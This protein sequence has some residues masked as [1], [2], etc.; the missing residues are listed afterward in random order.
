[1]SHGLVV[2]ASN[3]NVYG[4]TSLLRPAYLRR[5][6]CSALLQRCCQVARFWS[7]IWEVVSTKLRSTVTTPRQLPRYNCDAKPCCTSQNAHGTSSYAHFAADLPRPWTTY[8]WYCGHTIWSRFFKLDGMQ[9]GHKIPPIPTQMGILVD[10]SFSFDGS[11]LT[12]CAR[13]FDARLV[14]SALFMSTQMMTCVTPRAADIGDIIIDVG[15]NFA[16]P[17]VRYTSFRNAARRIY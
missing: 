4:R 8:W 5:A 14:V 1:M 16:A 7:L 6:V 13:R 17:Q 9:V 12:L 10:S 11:S 15:A 2:T 3:A